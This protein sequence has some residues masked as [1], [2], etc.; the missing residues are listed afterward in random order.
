MFFGGIGIVN[1]AAPLQ[2]KLT[3][4]GKHC[5][6]IGYADGHAHGT[7]KMLNLKT[8]CIWMMRYIC[9]IAAN[10]VKYDKMSNNPLTKKNNKD[11]DDDD[12]IQTQTHAQATSNDDNDEDEDEAIDDNNDKGDKA[13]YD[14]NEDNDNDTNNINAEDTNDNPPS[15]AKSQ[16]FHA[17]QNLATSYNLYAT[18][19][20]D[21]HHPPMTMLTM[22]L[23]ST[24]IIDW[25]GMKKTTRSRRSNLM[26]KSEIS[27]LPL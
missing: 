17:M 7:F 10:I 11:D 16:T 5:M 12:Y 6:F 9:W 4:Q 8:H 23:R 19:Y 24:K 15:S 1:D 25:E 26:S 2:S 21:C 13:D 27:T 3:N 22:M 20:V 14:N 18:D